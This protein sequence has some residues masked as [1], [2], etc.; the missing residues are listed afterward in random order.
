MPTLVLPKK[1]FEEGIVRIAKL[2]VKAGDLVVAMVPGT[3][4][5][6]YAMVGDTGPANELG[7]N[8]TKQKTAW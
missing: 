5:P 6:V 2:N 3:S 4:Q 7:F 8:S 1:P